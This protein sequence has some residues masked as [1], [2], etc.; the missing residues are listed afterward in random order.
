MEIKGLKSDPY[1]THTKQADTLQRT[2]GNIKGKTDDSAR[3]TIQGDTVNFSAE[4]KHRIE[5]Y[6]EAMKETNIREE[7]IAEI[8]AAIEAGTYRINANDIAENI[9][10]S[11]FDLFS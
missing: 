7:K 4:A 5:G 6:R 9:L 8:K 3:E 11:E 2:Q 10:R 1:S